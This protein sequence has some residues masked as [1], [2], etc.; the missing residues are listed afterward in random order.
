ML[1]HVCIYSVL[2]VPCILRG[3]IY[4]VWR[5]IETMN[6]IVKM[7]EG[8]LLTCME[9]LQYKCVIGWVCID[10]EG[11][12]WGGEFKASWRILDLVLVG[13]CRFS[14]LH[15]CTLFDGGERGTNLHCFRL[16]RGKKLFFSSSYRLLFVREIWSKGPLLKLLFRHY[17]VFTSLWSSAGNF[18]HHWF[19]WISRPPLLQYIW[20][21]K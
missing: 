12:E 7:T 3:T 21:F 8:S 5:R 6:L 20:N 9:R 17:T 2:H 16:G 4:S 18:T 11:C 15:R 10:C 13:P 1:Y 19:I 14:G